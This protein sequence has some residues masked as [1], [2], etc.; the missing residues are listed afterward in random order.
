MTQQK[1]ARRSRMDASLTNALLLDDLAMGPYTT[2][3]LAKINPDDTG[4][5]WIDLRECAKDA[6]NHTALVKWASGTTFKAAYLADATACIMR[7]GSVLLFI[8]EGM[9]KCVGVNRAERGA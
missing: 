2:F 4:K 3:L 9:S 7:D 5:S 8:G 1:R 6:K